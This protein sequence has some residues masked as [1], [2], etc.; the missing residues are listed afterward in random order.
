MAKKPPGKERKQRSDAKVENHPK[1]DEI[2]E[3][4]LDWE[5]AESIAVDCDDLSGESIRRFLKRS[6]LGHKRLNDTET[7]LNCIIK[8]GLSA[9]QNIDG[10]TAVAAMALRSKV[11][12]E[13]QDSTNI[14]INMPTESE[15]DKRLT[16]SAQI[17][18]I[19]PDS[20]DLAITQKLNGNSNG[21]SG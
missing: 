21:S 9:K 14:N 4:L 2:V 3:R 8:R 6:G 12:G 20:G 10:R 16:R 7:A 13:V 19:I 15:F 17:R 1:H 11:R 5:P 18:R